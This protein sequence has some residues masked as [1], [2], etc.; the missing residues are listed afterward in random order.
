[1]SQD[2]DPAA[3]CRPASRAWSTGTLQ[4]GQAAIA[5]Q[6]VKEEDDLEVLKLQQELQDMCKGLMCNL[7]RK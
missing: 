3:A 5:A 4:T 2:P 6:Q 1:M 7:Q